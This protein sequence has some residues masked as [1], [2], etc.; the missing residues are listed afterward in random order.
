MPDLKKN[1]FYSALLTVAN[2][3]FPLITYPYVSRVLGLTGI[4]VCNF[5][6]SIVNYFLVFSTMGIAVLGVREIA[7]AGDDREKRTRTFSD[8]VALIGLTTLIAAVVLLGAI[9][10][11]PKLFP[12][13]KLLLVSVVKLIAHSLTMEWFYGGIEN[14]KYITDRSIII[15]CFYVASIFLFVRTAEDY[16]VYYILLT[17]MALA[18][19]LVNVIHSRRYTGFT[20]KH[21]DLKRYAL[22]FFLLGLN[23]ILS[24]VYSSF[25]T[26]F[27]GFAWGPDEVGKF[28]TANKVLLMLIALISAF[29]TVLLPRM[30]AVLTDGRREEFLRYVDHAVNTLFLV[31]IPAVFIIQTE[32]S[33][34]IR[35]ISG[36]GYEGAAVP[37]M[38]IAPMV[39]IGGL[40]QILIIQTMIP[41]KMDRRIVINS[42]IGAGV[43]L[44]LALFLIRPM[45]A[46]GSAIVWIGSELAV[47]IA[48][49]A[50]VFRKDFITFPTSKVLRLFLLYLPLLGILLFI[51]YFAGMDQF[52]LRFA[53]AGAVTAVYF[54]IVSVFIQKDPVVLEGIHWLFGRKRA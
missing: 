12:Y 11:V 41:L 28:T 45:G 43:G 5:V 38:T 2:Y 40:E 47:C 32:S 14:F 27:L 1:F 48:A 17:A 37:M 6:D 26:I 46:M 22:P 7:A 19:M 4:G 24:S 50:A 20:L 23:Y 16:G 31:G 53:V 29:T 18:N 51:R 13:R 52:V 44:A 35:I 8:L 15:K 21:V 42:A 25:N 33:D 9:F 36:A 34:I 10:V 3:V 54:I 39:I 49:S 30:S